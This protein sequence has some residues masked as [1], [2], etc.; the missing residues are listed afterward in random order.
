MRE[1]LQEILDY[2]YNNTLFHF[3]KLYHI[4]S[5]VIEIIPDLTGIITRVEP[6]TNQ[7]VTSL[8]NVPWL[9]SK[10]KVR[11][12]GISTEIDPAK[13]YYVKNIVGDTTCVKFSIGETN[14]PGEVLPLTTPTGAFNILFD[15]SY[16]VVKDTSWLDIGMRIIFEEYPTPGSKLASIPEISE[17]TKYFIYDIYDDNKIRISTSQHLENSVPDSHYNFSH[18]A[19]SHI[20]S[21]EI[22]QD[23]TFIEGVTRDTIVYLEARTD[24]KIRDFNKEFGMVDLYKLFYILENLQEYPTNSNIVVNNQDQQN[25]FVST[26]INFSNDNATFLDEYQLIDRS[27]VQE[28]HP[29]M[30]FKNSLWN[31]GL[32]LTDTQISRFDFMALTYTDYLTFD[33]YTKGTN[34]NLV[35]GVDNNNRIISP[36]FVVGPGTGIIFT[37]P[38]DST[39]ALSQIGLVEN[40]VYYVKTTYSDGKFT[41]SDSLGGDTL[42]L[43]FANFDFFVNIVTASDKKVEN[44][45]EFYFGEDNPNFGTIVFEENITGT[46]IPRIIEN[47]KTIVTNYAEYNDTIYRQIPSRNYFIGPFEDEENTVITIADTS[48]LKE[49]NPIRFT[50]P[51]DSADAVLQAGLDPLATYYVKDILDCERFTFSDS[52]NGPA[53]IIPYSN[54]ELF[55]TIDC[56]IYQLFDFTGA[57]PVQTN[58]KELWKYLEP[59]LPIKFRNPPDSAEA[60]QQAE[61][62]PEQTYYVK[63]ITKFY[64]GEETFLVTGID[65][66]GILSLDVTEEE[67]FIDVLYPGVEV[68]FANLPDSTGALEEA[69]LEDP[70][71]PDPY[72]KF[73]ILEVYPGGFFTLSNE[74]YGEQLLLPYSNFEFEMKMDFVRVEFTISETIGGPVKPV[75][76]SNFQFEIYHKANEL[77]VD[78]TTWFRQN[79]PIKFEAYQNNS[80]LDDTGILEDQTYYIKDILN[81][82]RIKISD[83]VN[84][85]IKILNNT[86]GQ[87]FIKHD[88]GNGFVFTSYIGTE[89]TTISNPPTLYT[90]QNLYHS[91]LNP[92]PNTKPYDHI[93]NNVSLPLPQDNSIWGPYY[94]EDND[95]LYGRSA[96][97]PIFTPDYVITVTN[98]LEEYVMTG[99]DRNGTFNLSTMPNLSFNIGDKVQFI[100]DPSTAAEHPFWIKTKLERKTRY[101]AP[102]SYG[103]GTT[104]I[105]WTVLQNNTYYYLCPWHTHMSGNISVPPALPPTSPE[106]IDQNVAKAFDIR[107]PVNEINLNKKYV[108]TFEVRQDYIKEIIANPALTG[109]GNEAKIFVNDRDSYL[110]TVSYLDK[111]WTYYM[112]Q[113]MAILLLNGDKVMRISDEGRLMITVKSPNG[114]YNYILQGTTN[115]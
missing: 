22:I 85:P 87:F 36:T 43:P 29:M 56:N 21:F 96:L 60:L 24:E 17:L 74:L 6:E 40:T 91:D 108:Y 110:T 84:G 82:N 76:Y 58:D 50:G 100:I 38:S 89:T 12:E 101:H 16:L 20:T 48:I 47:F 27:N 64:D 63:E 45:L 93:L 3:L 41:I 8:N 66:D 111:R 113:I 88:T 75:P 86:D 105:N 104:V 35:T 57:Y 109:L 54:F 99:E 77:H 5:E 70:L 106:Y 42:L 103:N 37:N 112:Q 73:Y 28:Q 7:L 107:R 95:Y 23:Q 83:T 44:N 72:R 10:M 32:N 78:D 51:P 79:M 102:G 98:V 49:N 52:I 13:Y 9:E 81:N 115:T 53:H 39:A 69:E 18:F 2:T 46:Y 31:F 33:L 97:S 61:L 67:G 68:Y 11:F 4:K 65:S 14:L 19:Q 90:R 59:N 92:I 25:E 1:I 62:D 94:Y 80:P 30:D 34:F 26:K 114:I 55:L 71:N 15:R